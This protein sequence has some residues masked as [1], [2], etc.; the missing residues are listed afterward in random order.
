MKTIGLAELHLAVLAQFLHLLLQSS[1]D[2]AI[3]SRTAASERQPYTI[4]YV[5]DGDEYH[6]SHNDILYDFMH[7][8]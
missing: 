3:T 4:D 8:Y 2:T 6:G 1:S 5:N 7:I